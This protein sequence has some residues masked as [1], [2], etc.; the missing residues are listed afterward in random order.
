[1]AGE[2]CAA[3]EPDIHRV[4]NNSDGELINLHVYTPPLH[5]YNLYSS[6]E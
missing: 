2:I 5:A 6:V 1:M 3:D 4:S